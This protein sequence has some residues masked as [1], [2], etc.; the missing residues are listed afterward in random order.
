MK[1]KLGKLIL[2]LLL[3]G[4]SSL[5]MVYPSEELDNEDIT[6]PASVAPNIKLE[7]K[8]IRPPTLR[9]W[10]NNTE[11]HELIK[12]VTKITVVTNDKIYTFHPSLKLCIQWEA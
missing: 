12:C 7:D 9:Y 5:P 10:W 2:P 8:F 3:A 4:C 6:K 1:K 11:K